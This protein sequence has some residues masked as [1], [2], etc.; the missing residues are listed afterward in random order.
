M[1][2]LFRVALLMLCFGGV[3][4]LQAQTVYN[5]SGGLVIMEMENTE[6]SLNNWD[7]K[8]NLSGYT[9]SGFLQFDANAYTHGP[10]DS[11]LEF[12]FKINEGGLYY[13]HMRCAKQ[14]I[15]G[16][17]D[18]ANDC[19]VRVEGDYNAGPGPYTGHGDNASLSLLSSNTKY[20][21]GSRDAWKWENGK[22]SS[23]S[24]GN[25]DPGGE[26]NKRVALYDF[27]AGETYKLV[28]SGRSRYFRMDRLMFRKS[29]V[30][31]TYAENLSRPES[32]TISGG[33]DVE[34]VYDATSD[35]PNITAGE[36]P[37][38]KHTAENALAID[39]S[40]VSY[41]DKFARAQLT[42]S[43][44]A[45]NYDVTITSLRE[46]DG[47]CTYRFLV[48]GSVVGT[49]QNSTTTTDYNPENHIFRNITIPAGATLAVESNTDSNGLVPEGDGFAWARG[50]WTTLTL[51]P[52]EE[53]LVNAP[54]GRIAY[55]ADG[56][57]PDPD[58]IGANAVVFGLLD[59]ANL[60]DRLVHF[61]HSCDLV[62]PEEGSSRMI[63]PA[64]DL[65]R[66][67]YMHQ[68]AAE[69]IAYFGPF[70]NLG[71]VYNCKADQA[72]AVNDLKNAIN[73]SSAGDPLWIIEAGEPDIIGYALEAA[74]ASARQYV[75][76]VSHHPANDNSGDFFTWQQILDFGV[77]EHQ[78]GDQNVGLKV[79]ISTGL[80]DWADGNSNPAMNWIVDQLKYAEADGVVP[81]Q[82]NYYDCSDAGMVYWWLTGANNGGNKNSTPVEIKEML[83]Y[84]PGQ[85]VVNPTSGLVA[86]WPLNEGTG[87]IAADT[88]DYGFV[89]TLLNG[90][91]WGSDAERGTFVQFDGTDDRISTTFSSAI[92]SSDNFTWAWWAKSAQS[93]ADTTQKGSIM[94][95]NRYPERSGN[96]Y[97]FIKMTPQEAQFAN[98]SDATTIYKYNYA[99]LPVN[100]WHHY[101]M[102]KN[103]TSYQ[104]YVD[105][106][107]QGSPQTFSYSESFAIPFLIG[108]D[109]DGSGTKVN[110]HF[111]GS[112]D[113]VVLYREALT[114]AE[115][116][117]V[118]NGIY[119]P[120]F[121]DNENGGL[122]Y[123]GSWDVQDGTADY[124]GSM[125]YSS[126]D[127]DYVEYT[128]DGSFVQVGVR[129]GGS[130][131]LCNVYIDGVLAAE[132]IDTYSATT[133][134]ESI[135][136]EAVLAKGSH[137]VRL[138]ATGQKNASASGANIMFDFFYYDDV[139]V[140]GKIE[141]SS[142]VLTYVGTWETQENPGD[143]GGSMKW[144]STVG[145]YVEST[146][147]GT[148]VQVGVRKGKSGGICNVYIDG[149]LVAGNVNTYVDPAVNQVVIHEATLA[150]GTHTVRLEVSDQ[151]TKN[152]MFDFF[153]YGVDPSIPVV[154]AGSD[155]S[156]PLPENQVDLTGSA[157]DDGTIV[158]YLW[159]QE[160][161]PNTASLTGE[162]TTSLSVGDL[163]A[164]TYV[165][166]LTATDDEGKSGSDTVSVVVVPQSTAFATVTSFTLMNAD[167]D[168]PVAGFDPI[169]DGATINKATAGTSFNIRVNTSPSTD[170]GSVVMALSGATTKNATESDPVWALFGD[171]A[172]DFNVAALNNGSHTMTATPYDQD[173]GA[174]EAGTPLTIN[175]TVV[176]QAGAPTA[177]AG[178]DQVVTLPDSEITLNGSGSDDGTIS[179]YAWTQVSGPNTA[180][181]ANESSEDLTASG[182][183]Q[184]TYVFRLTVTDNE[185]N[186][187]ADDVTVS[188]I[189]EGGGGAISGELKQWHK[190]TL[191][192]DGPSSSETAA[193]N[194]FTDYRM[195][196]TFT[197]PDSGLS[198]VVPGYFAADGNAANT[199]ATSGNKW[200]AHISPDHVGTWNYTVSF[201]TG[202][203]VAMNTSATA[204]TVVTPYNGLT[205]SFVV[206]ATDKT[207]RDHRG[208]GRLEYVN[209]HHLRFAG[210][211]E[212][213]LKAGSD[214]PENL[215]AYNDIDATPN[216]PNHL[217]N[218]RKTW[219]PHAGDYDATDAAAY[220]WDGGKGSELLGAI[221]YLSDE[222]MNVF[223]FLTFGLDGDDDNVF[224]HLLVG[225]VADYESVADNARWESSTKGVHHDRFDISKMSQW[226]KIFEYG[227]KKGMYL[228]FK[229]QETE[230]DQKM[231]GGDLGRE[232]K[233]YYR[234]LVARYGHHLA[235]NWN[236]GEE[237]RNTDAQ[238]K[239]FAQWFH[240]NDPYR[241]NVV[242]HTYPAAKDGVYTPMLGSASKLTGLSL[243]TKDADFNLVFPDTLDWVQ[244][245]AAAGKPW[246]V[247][248]DEPG[249]ANH[250]LRPAGDEGNS[251]IDGRKN[252]LWGN[253]MAGG[254]G[255]EFYFGYQHDNS[256]MTCQD[257]RSRDGFWDYCR[258][259]LEFFKN[260]NVPFWDMAN[261]DALVS[262]AN[263]W[264]LRKPGES[265]VVYLKNGGTT[266]LNLGGVSGT[267]NVRWFDP[268]NGGS[269]QNGSVTSVSGGSTVSLGTAPSS[270][271]SDWVVLVQVPAADTPPTISAIEDQTIVGGTSTDPLAFTIGDSH[272][273]ADSLVLTKSSSDTVLVPL[274]NIVFGGS[275]ASRTVTVT[276][277]AGQDGDADIGIV[278]SD[279]VFSTTNTFLLTV[280]PEGTVVASVTNNVAGTTSWICPAGV[281]SI[282]VECWGGGGA[283]GAAD[284]VGTANV[285]GG[286]GAGGAYAMKTSVPV[287]PGNSY[288]ITIPAA[289]TAPAGS[290]DGAR[291]DGAD[292]SFAGDSVTVT[293][294]GGQ[295]GE[296]KVGTGN[297]SGAG[298]AASTAGCVGDVV[299]AGG[300]GSQNGDRNGGAGGGG[301]GDAA[302]GGNAVAGTAG[303]GGVNGGGNG[304]G[305]RSGSNIGKPGN[306]PGGGG[307][308][309][310]SQSSAGGD[311]YYGGVGGLGQIIIT[312]V[313]TPSIEPPILEYGVSGTGMV[314]DWSGNGFKV[315]ARTNL[316]EGTWQDVPGGDTPPVTNSTTDAEAFFRL[317]EQ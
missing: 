11:P 32:E 60:Q 273:A 134:N 171:V 255:V 121:I 302:T 220:T 278:V 300:D 61:S 68:E 187:A 99:D 262:N 54:A 264:C 192:I 160:S 191:M 89:G 8:T 213:F 315:Q 165:F 17:S 15:D 257:F 101:A 287:T 276:P 33:G 209:K 196:V 286:G 178:A 308:G 96:K 2:R 53:S 266:T 149:A 100:E 176:D 112:I 280:L 34:Y 48:N 104:W 175:F 38:Y 285:G 148:S 272:T 303:L 222:S 292:V 50:R 240:D 314:F 73:A 169:A 13:L 12:N 214:A 138:E 7:K 221:K 316:T 5:E 97:G 205:G 162:T 201:R 88:S 39:A 232:R 119:N 46:L 234:E 277:A 49:A 219:S 310:K 81:F 64:D 271:T 136:Y 4:Q 197:H 230:N 3:L 114:A 127:G 29:T 312:Y 75:H 85:E 231:D 51:S 125:S 242:L 122:T 102:V 84:E 256:D 130:G 202:T 36:V 243:Q 186:E 155:V 77:T 139:L 225:S 177:D 71:A 237:N 279:G 55:V 76:V 65:R 251:W 229:T 91:T 42:F 120:G 259:M 284:A 107:A 92:S 253:V 94:V 116:V 317:I 67:N 157:T 181:L 164:G 115:V 307:G 9:G 226:E 57:S 141:D 26:S 217:P 305:G 47:E 156:I 263:A 168:V 250:A 63:D 172:G 40:T 113:D 135:I 309:A 193:T 18:V 87:T 297:I 179:M 313:Q 23:G 150:A 108:G 275:G 311:A 235:M 159:T 95:G 124:E 109:D 290:A 203:D 52:P 288:T 183:V 123:S 152:I 269:L 212:Y 69:A 24:A 194:P 195:N 289:A 72:G 142:S 252:A 166:K 19:Y 173:A 306:S 206:S 163:V 6:S 110:E 27:K 210:T 106:V 224:P 56:N 218:L 248:C 161:G 295:G 190:V 25:L 147:F 41:R 105:G 241:H 207:G 62:L 227:D 299:F 246:V 146:F 137:T 86:H 129:K 301:A 154:N 261:Q 268:R 79:L 291:F 211:G 200:A 283:G 10:A 270:T 170:F 151:N 117:G 59:G 82:D 158:S 198:Y 44:T 204:G 233:V 282:Q 267:F 180:T 58:D 215:L 93:A 208:K 247:A 304:G 239:A 199:G 83:L 236:L 145:D 35:F 238:R 167:T 45:G 16:R 184:G 66:Q 254:A 249:D 70:N 1:K 298:G 185:S 144:S 216:D 153:D 260:N 98:T 90:A 258:Y 128:F 133:I 28:V 281:T 265:Y 131:G 21:G 274:A 188:V 132:N 174:G 78:I 223:S 31:E 244:Q 140:A 126:T 30:S 182:L 43:G 74:N 80:W 189:T 293:A 245:S 296:C 14:T 118:K 143:S 228:H 294:A 22:N 20:F 111:N 103:G 37:Y